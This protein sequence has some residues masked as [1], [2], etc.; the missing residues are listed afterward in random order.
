MEEGGLDKRMMW[1][2]QAAESREQQGGEVAV[3][4][5]AGPEEGGAHR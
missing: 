5:G 3:Q 2:V 4:K 1:G